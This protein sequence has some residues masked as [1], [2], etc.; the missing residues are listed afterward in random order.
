MRCNAPDGAAVQSLYVRA[1]VLVEQQ[2][3]RLDGD[4]RFDSP[5]E[6]AADIAS[7]CI[8]C[9]ERRVRV[10][11][12]HGAPATVI[13]AAG[14][15]VDERITTVVSIAANGVG[16]GGYDQGLTIVHPTQN[17]LAATG[18]NLRRSVKTHAKVRLCCAITFERG[19]DRD[20]SDCDDPRHGLP[21]TGAT[22]YTSVCSAISRASSTSM[23]K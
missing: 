16:F 17:G 10:F 18:A 9:I 11:S 19:P 4:G 20:A 22:V 2:Q 14:T 15:N 7:K 5:G 21:L 6:E 12:T 13:E 8:I 23:P 3:I 1:F